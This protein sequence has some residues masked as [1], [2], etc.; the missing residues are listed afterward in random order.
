M[1]IGG[2]RK[3]FRVGIS[4]FPVNNGKQRS[5]EGQN[6]SF[7]FREVGEGEFTVHRWSTL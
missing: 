5:V 7:V 2:N 3:A 4:H 6:K 1:G